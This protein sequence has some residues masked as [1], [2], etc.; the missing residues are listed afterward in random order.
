MI[1][2]YADHV[3]GMAHPEAAVDIDYPE[4]LLNIN[5]AAE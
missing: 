3:V 4:D 1:R 2:R 5:S